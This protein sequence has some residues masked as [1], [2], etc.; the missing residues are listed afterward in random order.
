MRPVRNPAGRGQASAPALRVVAGPH[1]ASVRP[2]SA[3]SKS[4]VPAARGPAYDYSNPQGATPSVGRTV[5]RGTFVWAGA[6]VVA[7]ESASRLLLVWEVSGWRT[8]VNRRRYIAIT[9]HASAY[10]GGSPL[11][12]VE[13]PAPYLRNVSGQ[14]GQPLTVTNS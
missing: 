10:S 6:G 9:P 4:D 13:P 11:D 12:R 8:T 5:T 7:G 1:D 2:V 14:I 3:A